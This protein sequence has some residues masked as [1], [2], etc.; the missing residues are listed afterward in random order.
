MDMLDSAL[1]RPDV[2][3]LRRGTF[4]LNNVRLCD[5]RSSEN[6]Q[7]I[8]F[9]EFFSKFLKVHEATSR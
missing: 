4:W 3:L 8:R 2:A 6:R 9:F 7:K 5:V 1:E